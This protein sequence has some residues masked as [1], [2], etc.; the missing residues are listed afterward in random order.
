MQREIKTNRV[1]SRVVGIGLDTTTPTVSFGG[2]NLTG[3]SKTGTGDVTATF[4]TNYA[5]TPVCVGCVGS[6]IPDGGYLTL[7]PSP[8][9]SSV[10]F[11]LL[12]S[13]AG[14]GDSTG[15]VICFGR[16]SAN[17][18]LT[19]PQIVKCATDRCV[20]L[21]ITVDGTGTASITTG[22]GDATLVDNGTG[23]YTLTF[24]P[25]FGRTPIIAATVQNAATSMIKVASKSAS[26]V[27]IK[28]FTD[29][30]VAA[31][32]IFHVLVLGTLSKEETGR[33]YAPLNGT[34]RL[35]R[36]I[37]VKVDYSGGV[38]SISTNA[39]DISSVTDNGTGD[40]T[41]TFANPFRRAPVVV[42]SAEGDIA[43]VVSV[44]ATQARIL[45]GTSNGTPFDTPAHVAILGSDDPAQY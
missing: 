5:D 35:Q 36:V 42:S 26:S 33:V 27:N 19:D 13:G 30:A 39:T 44:S 6:G 37:A 15:D 38:P 24:T 2:A 7:F 10:R 9:T 41:L 23:D 3:V 16:D 29:A 45:V 14:A 34:Q 12:N 21:G 1:R 22:K 43:T 32:R 4:R 17:S 25:A 40:F 8:T 28:T 31:D 18:E 20:L 11:R